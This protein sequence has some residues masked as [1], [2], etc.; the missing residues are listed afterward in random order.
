MTKP[1]DPDFTRLFNRAWDDL[2]LIARL[3]RE[4]KNERPRKD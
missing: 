2:E 1:H 3:S 4:K